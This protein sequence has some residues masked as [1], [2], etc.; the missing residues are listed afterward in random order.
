MDLLAVKLKN[1][2]MGYYNKIF[3]STVK[4][5][6]DTFISLNGHIFS[7]QKS[8]EV[9]Q[10]EICLNNAQREYL[11]IPENTK[12]KVSFI[13]KRKVPF[14]SLIKLNLD[15]TNNGHYKLSKSEIIS[16]LLS[17]FKST[18]FNHNQA[19][20]LIFNNLTF[21]VVVDE[22]LANVESPYGVLLS[23]SNIFIKS[24]SDRLELT[25]EEK[26]CLL[27]SGVDFKKLGI[28]G[29]KQEFNNMFRRAF[30][31][32]VFEKNIIEQLGISH[33]KGILLYGPPGTGKTLIAR[34]IGSILNARTPKIVNGPEIL[35]KYVGQS[36]ENIRNLF[37]DAE[38]EYKKRGADSALHIIIFDE[39]DAVFR[40]RGTSSNNVGDQ[41]V[42]QLLSKMDGVEAL[43]N[44]L[45]IG[46][47]NRKD[48]IDSALLR[49]GR[50]EM[51]IEIMLPDEKSRCE[52]FKIHTNKMIENNFVDKNVNLEEMAKLTRN[53]TGA[54]IAALVKSAVSFALE[55]NVHQKEGQKDIKMEADNNVHITMNDFMSALDEVKPSYGF[56]ENEF[57]NFNKKYYDIPLFTNTISIA[58]EQLEKLRKTSAYKTASVIFHG[59]TGTGKT[60]IAVKTAL[61]SNYPFIKMISPK[62]LVGLSE[63][64][65][66]NF[67]K[68]VF[69]DAYRSSESIVILDDLETLI[70]YVAIGPRFSN[71]ILQAL[72]I[73]IKNEE[74]NKLFVI[75]VTSNVEV[76]KECGLFDCFFTDLFVELV[77]QED[78]DMLKQQNGCFNDVNYEYPVPIKSIIS[79]VGND[80][81]DQL[82]E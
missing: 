6:Q 56:N 67:I 64:E 28:G 20:Y 68:D 9:Q 80:D 60:T 15:I 41:V 1:K 11:K 21:K 48:L 47:T 57:S 38:E 42:N 81:F 14:I 53:Y 17:N 23:T 54:E 3:I 50:F 78:F 12:T 16:E 40:Q 75:G 61:N 46:M 7:Y 79:Q 82:S 29:L 52:I 25:G 31:Q 37:K 63:Y 34:Q 5:P 33:L 69:M 35:N 74:K 24:V 30:M 2:E 65:K 18:P 27:R 39:L 36:E 72:K 70:E 43:D 19:F 45:V 62:N 51:H 26:N 32:R 73:Y 44:I 49:P 10:H 76:M 4:T 77:S 8:S 13:E 22:L 71:N 59:H 55:R 66:V 58:K